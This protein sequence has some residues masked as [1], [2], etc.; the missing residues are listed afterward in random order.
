MKTLKLFFVAFFLVSTNLYLFGQENPPENNNSEIKTLFKSDKAGAGGYGGITA[1][2]TEI[3]TIPGMVVGARGCF[4]AG[5]SLA[6]GIAANGIFSE[7]TYNDRL[8][9]DSYFSGGYGGLCIEPI[10]L[11]KYPIHISVPIVMGAGGISY[12][13]KSSNDDWG[14]FASNTS[15]VQDTKSFFIA[16]PGVELEINVLKFFRL[17]M[18]GYYRFTSDVRL[19]YA[20]SNDLIEK[21]SFLRGFS[22]G[23]TLKLGKF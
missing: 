18:G 5:H 13:T 7:K 17:A 20:N 15:S 1:R 4:I 16:E 11:P 9:Q 14:L 3:G 19:K 10:F 2:Y 23:V 21:A 22:V 6:I 8:A 12:K